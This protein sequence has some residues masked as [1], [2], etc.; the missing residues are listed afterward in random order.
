MNKR[1]RLRLYVDTTS[2]VSLQIPRS[3][4]APARS[5][6][7]RLNILNQVDATTSNYRETGDA[8]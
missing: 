5:T 3:E 2:V 7:K 8:N 1:P 4:L 6:S